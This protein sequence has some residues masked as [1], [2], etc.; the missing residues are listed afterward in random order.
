MV[1]RR[2]VSSFDNPYER[3]VSVKEVYVSLYIYDTK[4]FICRITNMTEMFRVEVRSGSCRHAL[5]V[6]SHGC[7]LSYVFVRLLIIYV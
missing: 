4:H 2:F 6:I 3:L 5:E 1:D 7:G